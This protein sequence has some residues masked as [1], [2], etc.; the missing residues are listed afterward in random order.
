MVFRPARTFADPAS[1]QSGFATPGAG[2]QTSG[3]AN[4]ATLLQTGDSPNY[5]PERPIKGFPSWLAALFGPGQSQSGFPAPEG[6]GQETVRDVQPLPFG[7]SWMQY[8][9]YFSRGAAAYAPNFGIVTSNPIGAGVVAAQRPQASY[10]PAAQYENG[11]LWWTS[12]DIPTSI[13]LQG[14]NSPEEL[15]AVLSQETVYAVV[16]TTG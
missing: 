6:P 10:G 9:P 2:A 12:Q 15:A 5:Q 8:T 1:S 16:R 3:P 7:G 13:N 14:L 11:A 4:A